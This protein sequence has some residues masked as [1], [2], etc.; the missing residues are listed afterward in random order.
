[1]EGCFAGTSTRKYCLG[2]LNYS[3]I[4]SKAEAKVSHFDSTRFK[5][6]C[7]GRTNFL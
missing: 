6:L 2:T 1:M 5:N 7:A 3:T 4:R